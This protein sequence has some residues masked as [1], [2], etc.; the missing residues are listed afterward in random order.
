M[1]LSV[2]KNGFLIALLSEKKNIFIGYW[3]IFYFTKVLSG[4]VLLLLNLMVVC[5]LFHRIIF[6]LE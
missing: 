4:T 6:K 2:L 5:E 1:I 3:V